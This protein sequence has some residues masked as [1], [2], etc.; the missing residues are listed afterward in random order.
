MKTFRA[1]SAAVLV[2]AA[3]FAQAG[4]SSSGSIGA[5][6]SAGIGEAV[7]ITTANGD[8]ITV[9]VDQIADPANPSDPAIGTQAPPGYR[10]VA[11]EF[12]VVNLS[13]NLYID[14]PAAAT[15][16]DIKGHTYKPVKVPPEVVT[17]ITSGKSSTTS[18]IPAGGSAI[19]AVV[20]EVPTGVT[21]A[22]VQLVADNGAGQTSQWRLR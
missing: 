20:F 3:V 19:G 6:E 22:T 17:D 5:P 18:D 7:N 11:A 15:L 1:V 2:A 10:L 21:T 12:R 13:S 8:K 4:C 9:T 14:D 16:T